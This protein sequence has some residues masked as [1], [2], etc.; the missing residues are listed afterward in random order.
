MTT[1]VGGIESVE[2][3]TLRKRLRVLSYFMG[4]T[5]VGVTGTYLSPDPWL[6]LRRERIGTRNFTE[7]ET[8]V[9]GYLRVK[10]SPSHGFDY[11]FTSSNK[12]NKSSIYTRFQ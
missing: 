11:D 5:Y 12:H 4:K 10:F 6:E 1:K 7:M 8:R 9:A 3:V 2:K